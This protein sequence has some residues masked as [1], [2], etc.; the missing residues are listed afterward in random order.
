MK[1]AITATA[2]LALG[3]SLATSAIAD[4]AVKPLNQVSTVGILGVPL[5]TAAI[6]GGV[7]V[8]GAVVIA[9]NDSSNGT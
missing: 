7:V 9:N 2:A 3:L 4:D 6:V 8:A 1:K 5:M